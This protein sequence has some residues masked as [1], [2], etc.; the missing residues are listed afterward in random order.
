[1]TQVTSH[2]N[3]DTA[4]RAQRQKAYDKITEK[5]KQTDWEPIDGSITSFCWLV[6]LFIISCV[7]P[8]TVATCYPLLATCYLPATYYFLL[9]ASYVR[10]NMQLL[11]ACVQHVF[12]IWS[13]NGC[14][15]TSNRIDLEFTCR[16]DHFSD[17]SKAPQ[18]SKGGHQSYCTNGFRRRGK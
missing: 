10:L 12:K 13:W 16:C 5:M 6:N 17:L 4:K 11:F 1:M 8:W 18:V 3:G 9:V 7:V 14:N 15:S 2:A